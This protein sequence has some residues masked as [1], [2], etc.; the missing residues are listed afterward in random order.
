M[1]TALSS[2]LAL[3][4]PGNPATG[5]ST[6]LA[7]LMH[8]SSRWHALAPIATMILS[9][10]VNLTVLLPA[11]SKVKKERQGQG[12]EVSPL[13]QVGTSGSLH[14]NRR[15]E[16]TALQLNATAR[17]GTPQAPTRLRCKP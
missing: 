6:G 8:E 13:S 9:S 1:Q 2:I 17:T 5:V 4:Y 7:G 10:L 15:P 11:T 16:L 14:P 12:E 3:T